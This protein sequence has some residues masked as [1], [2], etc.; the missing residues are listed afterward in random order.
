M[1]LLVVEGNPKPIRERRKAFGIEPYYKIFT[2]MLQ[3][4]IPKTPKPHGYVF[5]Y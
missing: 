1:K 2:E 4:L 5:I 3:F